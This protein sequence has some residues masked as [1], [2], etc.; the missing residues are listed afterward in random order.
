MLFKPYKDRD[1]NILFINFLH[2]VVLGSYSH[3]DI[4]MNFTQGAVFL[5]NVLIYSVSIT[6][7]VLATECFTKYVAHTLSTSLFISCIILMQFLKSYF[8]EIKCRQFQC[9]LELPSD[10]ALCFSFLIFTHI[11][12]F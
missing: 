11:L 4:S 8:L 7:L 3:R 6:C 1:N 5:Q 2:D 9:S 12:V 10:T